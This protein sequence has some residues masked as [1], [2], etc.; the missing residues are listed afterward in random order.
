MTT[1][2]RSQY[3][4][5]IDRAQRQGGVTRVTELGG[6]AYTV[7]GSR[8]DRYT[9]RID[10]EGNFSCTCPAGRHDTPCWHEAAAWLLRVAQSAAGIA[11]AA[12]PAT[13][14]RESDADTRVRLLAESRMNLQRHG[15]EWARTARESWLGEE[16]ST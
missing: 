14:A 6:G 7:L 1:G 3:Q 2:T 11:P 4:A 10:L 5:C 12:A 13:V 9:V 15:A 16:E 8:G